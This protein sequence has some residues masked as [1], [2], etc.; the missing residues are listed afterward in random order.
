MIS[1]PLS[2]AFLKVILERTDTLSHLVLYS[3]FF[4]LVLLGLAGLIQD[5]LADPLK[6]F[7]AVRVV[8]IF[9]LAKIDRQLPASILENSRRYAIGLPQGVLIRRKIKRLSKNETRNF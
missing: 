2:L 3:Q 8:L 6:Y 9:F 4:V 5:D 1:S 7:F